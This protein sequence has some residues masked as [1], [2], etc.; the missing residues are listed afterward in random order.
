MLYK[1]SLYMNIIIN[2]IVP[3][4]LRDIKPLTLISSDTVLFLLS[5]LFLSH[6]LL[7]HPAITI[8][9]LLLLLT[10]FHSRNL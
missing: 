8:L 4:K 9:S 2:I 6:A 3:R 7:R 10:K 1:S 5:A